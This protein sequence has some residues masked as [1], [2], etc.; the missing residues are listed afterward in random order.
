VLDSI[1]PGIWH[2]HLTQ[3]GANV[4]GTVTGGGPLGTVRGDVSEEP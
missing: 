1:G 4:S 3:S 2:W